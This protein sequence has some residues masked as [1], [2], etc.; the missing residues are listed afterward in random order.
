V[1]SGRWRASGAGPIGGH[2]LVLE[3][4]AR[5]RDEV[6]TVNP[7]CLLQ[8]HNINNEGLKRYL[9]LFR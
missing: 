7:K 6:V 3:I 8:L 9:C 2:A 5:P 1:S 4:H